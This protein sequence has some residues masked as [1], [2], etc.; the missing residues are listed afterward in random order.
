M[1]MENFTVVSKQAASSH[2]CE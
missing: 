2:C 1:G